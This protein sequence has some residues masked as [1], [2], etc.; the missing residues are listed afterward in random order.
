MAVSLASVQMFYFVTQEA[1]RATG[2]PIAACTL[3]TIL[4]AVSFDLDLEQ[5]LVFSAGPVVSQKCDYAQK[6][7]RVLGRKKS[8]GI[9]KEMTLKS[10]LRDSAER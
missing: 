3:C 5:W 7:D 10:F 8:S 9:T 6:A 1:D 2:H 4:R